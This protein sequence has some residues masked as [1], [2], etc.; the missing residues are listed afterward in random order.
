MTMRTRIRTSL[1]VA[2]A[3]APVTGYAEPALFNGHFYEIV[4]DHGVTWVVANGAANA[5]E[6]RGVRG[7]LATLTSAEEDAF[8]EG[9]R[10]AVMP[11]IGEVWIGGFQPDGELC[12]GCGWTWVNGEGS[13]PGVS[14]VSPYANW[15]AGEPNDA[16]DPGEQHLAKGLGGDPGWNDEGRVANIGGYVIEYDTVET[17]PTTQCQAAGGCSL[18]G[19]GLTLEIPE[20]PDQGN[21]DIS[22]STTFETDPRFSTDPLMNRCGLEPWVLYDDDPDKEDLIIPEYLC[23]QPEVAVLE[24]ESELSIPDGIVDMTTDPE[25]YFG[26]DA[27]PCDNPILAGDP[28]RGQDVPV[29]QP[30]NAGDVRE[31]HALEVG[32][33]CGS[34]RGKI[35]GLSYFVVG[36]HIDCGIDGLVEP[37]AARQCLIDLTRMKLHGLLA[38]IAESRGA[39]PRRQFRSIAF[40]GGIANLAFHFGLYDLASHKLGLLIEKVEAANYDA[41]APGNPRGDTLMRAY[42]AKFMTDVK[43]IGLMN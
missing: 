13:I 19:G 22:V 23:G 9:L 18:G 35:R 27:L 32:F 17:V 41:N 21:P 28:T 7:H 39:L 8:V 20:V 40:I 5:A 37:Q 42:N 4:A 24:I 26:D 31:G 11:P 43:V 15:Q 10:S 12:A 2:L 38:S 36:M 1:L 6:F 33:D 29:W 30:T 16:F 3:V 14:S 34:G 25:V